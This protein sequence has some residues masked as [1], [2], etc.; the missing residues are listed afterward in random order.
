MRPAPAP[1]Q[2]DRWS[3]KERPEQPLGERAPP[4]GRREGSPWQ[5]GLEGLPKNGHRSR[6]PAANR[7]AFPGAFSEPGPVDRRNLTGRQAIR[8]VQREGPGAGLPRG[9]PPKGVCREPEEAPRPRRLAAASHRHARQGL[10]GL[11][12]RM[13]PEGN[14]WPTSTALSRACTRH[15]GACGVRWKRG[16]S[17][18][19]ALSPPD[20]RLAVTM[21][22]E[23]LPRPSLDPEPSFPF[24]PRSSP[25]AAE[26]ETP[27]PAWGGWDSAVPQREP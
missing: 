5:S 27:G 8:Y 17:I 6:L 23:T 22:F 7:P 18:S 9:G 24:T 14:V 15:R 1:G 21:P 16:R 20:T 26:K 12:A 11:A 13:A 4:S 2:D 3:L 19:H 25:G 10:P